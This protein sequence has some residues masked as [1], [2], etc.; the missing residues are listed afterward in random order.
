LA[1]ACA[2]RQTPAPIEYL[3]RKAGLGREY[4]T[5]SSVQHDFMSQLTTQAQ[6]P[7]PRGRWIAT[8]MRWAGLLHMGVLFISRK[9]LQK[10]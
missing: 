9:F 2:A 5:P 1:V 4:S 7:G 6:R 10:S 8:A 3:P